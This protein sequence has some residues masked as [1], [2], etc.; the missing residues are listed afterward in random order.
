MKWAR[1]GFLSEDF[2]AVVLIQ[3]RSVQQRSLEVVMM[4]HT[5]KE[6]YELLI[7]SEG[8][9]TLIILEGLD[10]LSFDHQQ[11]DPFFTQLIKEC[12]VFKEAIVIITS[13]PYACKE[14]VAGRT[15]E[16]VGFGNKEIG[17]F[18]RKNFSNDEQFFKEFLQQL[19]EFPHL[20]SLCYVP[21]N[22]AMII[23]IFNCS[24]NQLPSTL[25][26]SCIRYLS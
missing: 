26:E 19:N 2:D 21:I 22:L 7:E 12:T 9:R 20:H 13:R 16:I 1:D 17:E 14:I 11:N 18:V 3:L 15:I 4:E 24:Q 8:T 6:T 25:T 23:N 10:E 5:G